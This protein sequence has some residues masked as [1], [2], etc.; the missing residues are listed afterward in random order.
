MMQLLFSLLGG[1][2]TG[3]VVSV[4]A[5]TNDLT[6][7]SPANCV[8][9]LRVSSTG[10]WY[11]SDNAGTY[12][13]NIGT[14]LTSGLNSEVWVERTLVTGTL[15]NSDPG[16]GRL[17]CS[18]NRTYAVIDTT[19]GG[20]AVSCEFTLDFYDAASGGSLIGTCTVVLIAS[21]EF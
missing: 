18:S 8:A 10:I 1:D 16:T 5:Q 17:V 2:P 20:G 21:K 6:S 12:S 13:T 9:G 19:T 11:L 3:P 15:N 4:S 7:I 14:W